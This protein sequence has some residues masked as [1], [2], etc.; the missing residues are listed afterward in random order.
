MPYTMDGYEYVDT[1]CKLH[2]S[3]LQCPLPRCVHDAPPTLHFSG[4]YEEQR[5]RNDRDKQ[6][7]AAR[8][9]GETITVIAERF[10]VSRGT[11]YRVLEA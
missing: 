11:V 10:K 3:C 4:G 6:I 7:V 2:P 9:A 8:V 5:Q 1:G